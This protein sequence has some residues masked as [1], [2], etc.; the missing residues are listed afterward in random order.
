MTKRVS[1]E[2]LNAFLE[3]LREICEKKDEK[4]TITVEKCDEGWKAVA[5]RGEKRAE[6]RGERMKEVVWNVCVDIENCT[7]PE[8]NTPRKSVYVPLYVQ[9]IKFKGIF[10]IPL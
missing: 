3:L 2:S 10:D 7:T 4:I 9:N 5:E 6:C 1:E 8:K